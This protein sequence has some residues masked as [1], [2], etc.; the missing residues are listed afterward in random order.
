MPN[1]E[2]YYKLYNPSGLFNQVLSLEIA[3]GIHYKTKRKIVLYNVSK[4][5]NEFPIFSPSQFLNKYPEL[6]QKNQNIKINDIFTWN[7]QE[8]FIIDDS[9]NETLINKEIN[10]DVQSMFLVDKEKE[11]LYIDEFGFNRN[12]FFINDRVVNFTNTLNFYSR[13]FF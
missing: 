9:I 4:N 11:L 5:I 8:C 7:G 3:A 12:L 13:F 10:Y 2:I 1:N 6:I